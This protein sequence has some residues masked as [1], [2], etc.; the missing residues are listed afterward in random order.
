MLR[1]FISFFS[2]PIY[3]H[4]FYTYHTNHCV[5][6]ASLDNRKSV[7]VNVLPSSP[8]LGKK[9]KGDE[10][11]RIIFDIVNVSIGLGIS[12]VENSINTILPHNIISMI[13]IFK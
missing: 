9:N 7:D 5:I 11:D 1:P 10:N 6:L 2:D 4:C 12:L 8:I 13:S 3:I